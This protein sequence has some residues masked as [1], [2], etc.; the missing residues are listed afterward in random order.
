MGFMDVKLTPVDEFL[1]DQNDPSNK[2]VK[3]NSDL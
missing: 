1:S 2:T 3:L